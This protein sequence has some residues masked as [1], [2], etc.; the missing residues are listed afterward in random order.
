MRAQRKR[1][2]GKSL[3][4]LKSADQLLSCPLGQGLGIQRDGSGLNRGEIGIFRA[5]V[6]P[7]HDED[8][9]VA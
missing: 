2:H 8:L 1:A 6:F 5:Q 4:G 7:L 3:V 9:C